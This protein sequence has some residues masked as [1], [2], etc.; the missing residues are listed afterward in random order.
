MPADEFVEEI[1]YRQTRHYVRKILGNLA[2]Y[3]ELYKSQPLNIPTT[4]P[5]IYLDNINF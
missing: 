5:A 4:I 2:V 1:P 3:Q